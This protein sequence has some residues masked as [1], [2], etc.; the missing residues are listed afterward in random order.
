MSEPRNPEEPERPARPRWRRVLVRSIPFVFYGLLAV[1]LAWILTQIDWAQVA[2]ISFDW[3]MVVFAT[4]V[5]LVSRF[6]LVAIWL[7]L[8]RRL[9]A[10]HFTS[11]PLLAH[12]Y[13]KAW[14]GRYIPGSAAWILG[15]IY[16]ASR[17]GVSKSKLA[18]SSF[19]EAGLQ[20]LVMLLVGLVLLMVDPRLD[21]VT[22]GVRITM[23]VIAVGCVVALWPPLFNGLAKFAYRKVRKRELGDEDLPTWGAIGQGFWMFAVSTVLTG[24]SVFLLARSIQSDL[25]ASQILFVVAANALASAVSMIAVFAPGGLGVREVILIALLT[26]IMPA[27]VAVL[28]TLLIRVWSIAVD[29]VFVGVTKLLTMLRGDDTHLPEPPTSNG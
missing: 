21:F 16:F 24:L 25:D 13:A 5:A 29:F 28:V 15:K 10:R 26:L 20:I 11:I 9:G 12:A 1:S 4:L 3:W 8:L 23:G 2:T 17:E 7:V 27:S 19:L 14:L 6:W 18:V 22:P